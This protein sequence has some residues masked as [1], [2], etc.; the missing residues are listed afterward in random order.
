MSNRT[1]QVLP[2]L[3]T[4]R[5]RTRWYRFQR[6]AASFAR[7]RTAMFGLI[8]VVAM[9]VSAVAAPWI[10]PHDPIFMEFNDLLESPNT[11]H[12]FGTDENGRDMFARIIWGGRVS[13]QVGLFSMF[14]AATVGVLA[15]LAAGYY[16]RWVDILVMRIVDAILALPGLLLA[17]FMVGILGPSLRNAMLAIAITFIPVFA[18]LTR[19]DTLAIRETEYVESA[20]AIGAGNWRIMLRAVLPNILSTII[21]QLSLGIGFAMLIEASLSFLGLGIQPPTPAWG[22]ML[23]EGRKY[24]TVAWWLTTIPGLAIFFAVLS[25][26]FI[27]DGLREALDPKQRRL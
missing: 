6:I 25:F 26:N 9:S 10:L 2:D 18:R 14:V 7:N 17:I 27:G 3:Q 15:G 22:S 12:W 20:R 5:R 16:G 1:E 21:V 24:M 8:L 4:Y 11:T 19:A 23:G 13:L